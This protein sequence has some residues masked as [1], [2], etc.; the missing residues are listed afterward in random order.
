MTQMRYFLL[1]LIA[2][3]FT[4]HLKAT[5]I[6]GGEM[7]YTCLGNNQYE[8]TLTI[9]RDCFNGSPNA[10]FDDP[11]SI[12]VFH[13]QTNVLLDE[14]LIPWDPMLN[15]TLDPVLSSVCLVAPPDVCVHTT[16]YTATI[17]LPP[18]AAGYTLAYQRCCRNQT[19]TNIVDPLDTGATYSVFIS[20]TALDVCNS[21]PK[22]QSWPPLY[23]C[24]NEPINFDQSAVDQDGDSIV[25]RLCTPLEGADPF[26]PQPQPPN[27][28][29]YNPI[30]WIDP[31]YNESNMLNGSPGGMPLTIDEDTGLLTGL[32]NTIGQ[33]VVGI[34]VEEYR[35]GVLISTTRRDFQYNV[36]ECGEVTSAFFAPSI[37]CGDLN[38]DFLN[39]SINA[40][41]FLW[42]FNYPDDLTAT[43]T[44][45]QPNY[46]YPDTGL[47]TVMLIAQP[48]TVCPD[49]SFQEIYL[50]PESLIPEFGY[51]YTNCGKNATIQLTDL[52]TDAVSTPVDW[53]WTVGG[54][55]SNA[56]NPSFNLMPGQAYNINLFV[57]AANG[58]TAEKDTTVLT[59]LAMALEVSSTDVSCFGANDGTASVAVMIGDPPFDFMWSNNQTASTIIDLS[60]GAYFVTV[61]D[62]NGC[63]AVDSVLISQGDSLEIV[64]EGADVSCFGAAD[65]TA[66]ATLVGGTPPY[67][68][69]W[70]NDATTQTITDLEPGLYEVTVSDSLGCTVSGS[71]EIFGPE[72]LLLSLLETD[73]TCFGAADGTVTATVLGGTEPYA[74]LW[75]NDETGSMISGLEP[76]V[77]G[78]TVTDANDC[79]TSLD[80]EVGGPD[81]LEITQVQLNQPCEGDD[82]GSITIEVAGGT[83]PYDIVWDDGQTGPTATGLTGGNYPVAITDG[84]GCVLNDT[85]DLPAFEN[86]VIVEILT[87]PSCFG[88]ST[89]ALEAFVD[90]GT[91]P[92]SYAWDGLPDTDP[93]ISGLPTGDYF[94]TVT[95][96]N[97]C[98]DSGVGL[99]FENPPA[100]CNAYVVQPISVF[101]GS[102]GSVAVDPPA[103]GT[104]PFNYAW[105]NLG[106][107][108]QLDGLAAGTYAVTITDAN[109]CQSFCEVTLE[110]PSK[111]G[112]KVWEDLDENGVQNAGEPGVPGV[113]VTLNGT[114]QDGNA[115][116]MTTTTDSEGLYLFD[117]LLP[118][119]YEVTFSDIDIDYGFTQQNVG[120]EATDSDADADGQTGPIA[121]DYNECRDNVDAGIIQV[122]FN[123]D[124]PGEISGDEYLCGPGNDPGPIVEISPASGGMGPIEYVWM[125]L[126]E[127]G[128]WTAIPNSN[129]PNFDPGPIYETTYFVRCVRRENCVWFV[130]TN[131]VVK[132]VG[133][134]AV[135][136]ING[137][138]TLCVGDPV[139]FAADEAGPGAVYQWNFG[140]NAQPSTASTPDVTVVYNQYGVYNIGL[141]VQANDCTAQVF[142]SVYVTNSPA[143][144][145]PGAPDFDQE[146]P[147]AA[148]EVREGSPIQVIEPALRIFPNPSKGLIHLSWSTG[149]AEATPLY[150]YDLSGKLHRSQTIEAGTQQSQLDLSDLPSGI[151]LLQYRDE[152]L[153]WQTSRVTKQ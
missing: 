45:F 77:Y 22:F 112:D 34:C 11:A 33:F 122:C 69:L 8:I 96:A 23:I 65:G 134:D 97:G 101:N 151:Y 125:F 27:N 13:G 58:C 124:D 14:I 120:D 68:Y 82:S 140:P 136:G 109:G 123:V 76:G 138:A 121:L 36:G 111:L 49:T 148:A 70:S 41:N 92:Y 130:E 62:L 61:T 56:Q 72:A 35:D 149:F 114:D 152:R 30:T 71:I 28:P 1:C 48:G 105:S 10:W 81:P 147:E 100:D 51:Q 102:D 47:Y 84:N 60:P 150:L 53:F 59:P 95:D 146:Q 116:S 133:T 64:V 25:Y 52:T 2:L 89:G 107:D 106:A 127:G 7:N 99:I 19:I 128:T 50:Q 117:G 108:Q 12:G 32:P 139:T 98:S 142:H 43:S 75:S 63:S 126:T 115:I 20:G 42:Y 86:P 153:G 85:I 143:N 80:I 16:T 137:P 24:V 129:T 46:V 18:L 26:D 4:V 3:C 119:D 6:V 54:F 88:G 17:T 141:T 15:D 83:E 44:E 103:D 135:A 79:S 5:H 9:F 113:T 118:G 39:N 74:Y 37:Q 90:G 131:I 57:T 132:E 104:A 29:P 93:V 144:C 38:V 110:N 31:P 40:D 73:V 21:N 91:P 55:T 87:E 67:T 78:V 66:T 145:G 94:L